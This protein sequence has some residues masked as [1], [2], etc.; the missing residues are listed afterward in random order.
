M[1]LLLLISERPQRRSPG[2]PASLPCHSS[3]GAQTPLH[4]RA[5][6]GPSHS[7]TCGTR[8]IRRWNFCSIPE[9]SL[10][11][12]G[13]RPSGRRAIPIFVCFF[14]LFFF[15]NF[16]CLCIPSFVFTYC[17]RQKLLRPLPK[18]PHASILV[19]HPNQHRLGARLQSRSGGRRRRA[20][21]GAVGDNSVRC[22]I[23]LLSD[24]AL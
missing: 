24:P 21:H 17:E 23:P 11:A 3:T 13:S 4:S 7:T 1:L 9:K 16:G 22:R 15:F 10:P 14:V 19:F 8:G 2:K 18:H 6:P 20:D 5:R 12:R